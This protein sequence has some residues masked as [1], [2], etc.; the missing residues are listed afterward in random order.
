VNQA[1]DRIGQPVFAVLQRRGERLQH[2]PDLSGR[3][4]VRADVQIA[5]FL[6]VSGGRGLFDDGDD[7]AAA[8]ADDPAIRVGPVCDGCQQREVGPAQAV[9]VDESA[10]RRRA[11]QGRI[12]IEDQQVAIVVF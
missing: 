11:E 1:V 6:V 8:I 4:H 10:N 5:D 3:D 7:A 12:A 2:R 9:A